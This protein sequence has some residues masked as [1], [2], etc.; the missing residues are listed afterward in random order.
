[1]ADAN[2]AV[3]E[4]SGKNVDTRTE[5]GG[6]HRQV[7]IP[8]HPTATDS[9]AETLGKDPSSNT[10]GLV[11]RDVNTSAVVSGLNS[12]RVR[13][14]VTGT[15][16]TVS[17][18]TDIAG[19]SARP[20]INRVHNVVDGTISTVSSVTDVAGFS[21]RPDI[22]RVH[23]VIDGTI[24]TVASVTD[25]A[26]FSARPD[27]NRVHNVIDGTIGINSFTPRPDI[28]RVHN[29]IDG[30]ISTVASV[31]D[32]AGF[33]ARP[34][35]NRVHNVVDG[36]ISTVASVTSLGGT[37]AVVQVSNA[38]DGLFNTKTYSVTS[39]SVVG[40]YPSGKTVAGPDAGDKIKVFALSVTTTAQEHMVVTFNN[41][42][43]AA[44]EYWRVGLQA[45]AQGVAG[46]NLAVAPPAHL[47]ATAAGST[48]AIAVDSDSLVHY[49]VSYFVES[50]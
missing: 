12:V 3:T 2:I 28:N 50:V 49:S 33:S 46:A 5:A 19:I 24:S 32:V 23:N 39:D 21:A 7:I 17:S 10:E 31:T 45:P 40:S 36:T 9:I 25:V 47:F 16:A 8:G 48:L 38:G 13:D 30:T 22:N 6:D 42:G 15:I 26:G 14:I 27:I 34:D 41:G 43:A 11:V 18:V 37:V 20:D 35:I 29:V 1:M 4:G 44:T